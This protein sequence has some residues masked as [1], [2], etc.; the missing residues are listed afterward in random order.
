MLHLT[1]AND[2]DSSE[3]LHTEKVNTLNQKLADL[4]QDFAT[5]QD[6]MEQDLET[7]LVQT[8]ELILASAH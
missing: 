8:L 2:L 7:P 5:V 1:Q 3:S 6:I 4:E